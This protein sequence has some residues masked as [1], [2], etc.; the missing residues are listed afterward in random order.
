LVASAAFSCKNFIGV[1]L[2]IVRVANCHSCPFV[3]PPFFPVRA[4]VVL[5][6][7]N[8]PGANYAY[9]LCRFSIRSQLYPI[10]SQ[11]YIIA[12]VQHAHH[13]EYR[14]MYTCTCTAV[15]Y[16]FTTPAGLVFYTELSL[17]SYSYIGKIL[18]LN[19]G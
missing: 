14:Q 3:S 7:I 16:V 15:E 4:H 1:K 11:L 19:N 12:R 17:L 10:R 2:L 8:F 9:R 13:F 5:L 18:G 6:V